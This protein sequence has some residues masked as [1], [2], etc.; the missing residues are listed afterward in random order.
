MS[1]R[2]GPVH[3]ATTRRKRKGKV[4][5]CHLLRRSFREDGKVKHETVG[6]LS[7]LPDHVIE[8][9]RRALRGE[10][11]VPSEEA[12]EI[13]RSWPHGHVAAVLGMLRQLEGERLLASRRSRARDLVVAMI[14]AR[15]LDP[16]SKL[17]TAR[18]LDAASSLSEVLGLRDVEVDELYAAMDWLAQRQ[19]AIERRLAA[20]HLESGALVF[21]DLTSTYFEGRHCPLARL[22]YSRDR[23][24][25]RLQIEFL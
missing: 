22:G 2:S 9:V 10:S 14:V 1:K 8:L 6:N 15:I 21:Y 11:F 25:N 12:L 17:A 3:V 18:G 20:R 7:H 23:K 19:P 24:R 16:R 13:Q 4:Y 5:T